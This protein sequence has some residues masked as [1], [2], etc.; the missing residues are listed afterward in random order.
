[1]SAG[2]QAGEVN[3]PTRTPHDTRA[4]RSRSYRNTWRVAPVFIEGVV[5]HPEGI[6]AKGVE[7]VVAHRRHRIFDGLQV[8]HLFRHL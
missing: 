2:T 1:M 8:H 3:V 5:L 6:L 4:P 7:D